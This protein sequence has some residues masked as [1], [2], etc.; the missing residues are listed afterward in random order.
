MTDEAHALVLLAAS[1]GI[2]ERPGDHRYTSTTAGR[3]IISSSIPGSQ[4]RP[5]RPST[6]HARPRQGADASTRCSS[7][8][9]PNK[10]RALIGN[11]ALQ[12]PVQFN[13]AGRAPATQFVAGKVLEIDAFNPQIAARMLD[14]LPQLAGARKR[15]AGACAPGPAESR[16]QRDDFP[17]RL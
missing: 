6:R 1:L 4:P 14:C 11:F 15:A 8:T 10:V 3:A 7:I 5:Y 17:G 13:Q 16:P 2:P 12:N 9:T